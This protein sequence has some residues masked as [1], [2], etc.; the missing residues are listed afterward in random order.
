MNVHKLFLQS[1]L[2]EG[3]LPLP[4]ETSFKGT[5][6]KGDRG[7]GDRL[8]RLINCILWIITYSQAYVSSL[9]II[10]D[11]SAERLDYGWG[12][13][14]TYWFSSSATD[15]LLLEID[16]KYDSNSV[17]STDV[18]H[19][20]ILIILIYLLAETCIFWLMFCRTDGSGSTFSCPGS[21][22]HPRMF[23]RWGPELLDPGL[24]K[25]FLQNK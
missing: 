13:M 14:G 25:Q 17:T 8:S 15:P 23:G 6:E 11:N 10:E 19:L 12:G 21:R 5:N 20:L 16:Q 18:Y 7:G 22:N 1:M 2:V 24:E 9:W 3:V 4:S